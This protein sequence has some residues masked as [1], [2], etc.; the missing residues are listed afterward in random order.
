[1]ANRALILRPEGKCADSVAYFSDQGLD[2]VGLGL[3]RIEP[4]PANT[5]ALYLHLGGI[6]ENDLVIV[7]S[8]AAAERASLALTTDCN[9]QLMAVGSSTADALAITQRPVAVPQ[10]ETTEGLLALPVLQPEAIVDRNVLILKGKGG[11]PLLADTLRARGAN[12]AELSLY[13]RAPVPNPEPTSPWQKEQIGCIVASSG[14][15]VEMAF[16]VIDQQFLRN[17]PWVVPSQRVAHIAEQAGIL[18]VYIS[19][20]AS[21]SSLCNTARTILE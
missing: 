12:V 3:M 13:W 16:D 14:E 2:A 9:G 10:V 6:G 11:R 8:T 4:L 17:T 7:V 15:L 5:A 21:N 1:M 18:R 20:G 19:E